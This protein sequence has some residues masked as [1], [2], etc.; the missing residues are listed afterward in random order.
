[1]FD[2]VQESS[3]SSQSAPLF[4]PCVA[5]DETEPG[6][7][8]SPTDISSGVNTGNLLLDTPVAN[9][10]AMANDTSMPNDASDAWLQSMTGHDPYLTEAISSFEVSEEWNKVWQDEWQDDKSWL[11]PS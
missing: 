1:M 5:D 8:K 10:T 4:S 11:V 9:D 6:L 3:N 2:V 7:T